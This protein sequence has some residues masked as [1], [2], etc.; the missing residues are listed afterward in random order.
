MSETCGHEDPAVPGLLCEKAPHPFGTHFNQSSKTF[1]AGVPMPEKRT[2]AGPRGGRP[3]KIIEAIIESGNGLKAGPPRTGEQRRDEAMAQVLD[4]TPEE[5]KAAFAA[6]YSALVRSGE[7]FTSEDVTALVGMPPGHQNA[8]G[9]QF[10]ALLR[11]DLA[12]GRVV[13][14][15]HVKALRDNQNATKIGQYQ[16][17]HPEA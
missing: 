13:Y 7:P 2:K 4:R 5:Y 14:L 15:A 6:R 17:Q 8:V 16:G 10:S 9:A 3:K 1:W 12:S 11:P